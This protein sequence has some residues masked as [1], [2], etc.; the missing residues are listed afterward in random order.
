MTHP[1]PHSAREE[2]AL[3]VSVV[4]ATFNRAESVARLVGEL[5]RQTLAADRF[6]VLVVDDGS[7]EPV[8]TRL[9][10]LAVPYELR[11]LTQPNA[12]PAAARHRALAQARGELVVIVDDDMRVTP[13][14]LAD[15]V[16][17]HPSG[18]R[19]AALGRIHIDTAEAQ[20]LFERCHMHLFEKL[21]RDVR[22]GTVTLRGTNLYTGNVSFHRR[23]YFAV[24]G[25]DTA[26]RLSEDAE[27]GVRLE[28]AGV[29]IVFADGAKTLS[30][31][32]HRSVRGWM[33]RSAAYGA[34]DSRVSQKHPEVLWANPWRFLFL[35]HP[36]SRPALLASALAP[37][38]VRPLA[39]LAM[40]VSLALARLGAERVA[41]AGTTFV[42]G[43]QYFSGVGTHAGSARRALAALRRFASARRRAT[44]DTPARTPTA[45][46]AARAC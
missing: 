40:G 13:T 16:G 9:R 10:A 29:Q 36:L 24:G 43:V 15:H 17:A 22:A 3:D 11:V 33:R 27:L 18:S 25:F 28:L 30:A 46:S 5:A 14:F 7:R 35:M 38:A 37:R 1:D 32:D 39:W 44:R 21:E 6:E 4:V 45:T 19:R 8:A 31:S 23:D 42:Y 2:H 20:P 34:A 26:F 12:G 41:I